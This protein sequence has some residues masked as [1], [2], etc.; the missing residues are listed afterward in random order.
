MIK[1]RCPR[2]ETIAV[3]PA[4]AFPCEGCGARLRWHQPSAFTSQLAL[5]LGG[6]QQPELPVLNAS[7]P[8][9][10]DDPVYPM[11]DQLAP[12]IFD[13]SQAGRIVISLITS[14]MAAGEGTD[15]VRTASLDVLYGLTR[16]ELVLLCM[17]WSHITGSMLSMLDK[18][19]EG[20]GSYYLQT[21]A[22]AFMEDPPPG[23]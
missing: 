11:P 20:L 18:Q 3:E 6:W 17:A 9:R 16:E 15:E 4:E 8:R 2:C 1:V 12:S 21:W 10:P 22:L 23:P 14:A 19:I 5:D 13:G 7:N